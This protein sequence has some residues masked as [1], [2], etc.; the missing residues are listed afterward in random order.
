MKRESRL[1]RRMWTVP[2]STLISRKC[3]WATHFTWVLW[4]AIIEDAIL[5]NNTVFFYL[6][7]CIVVNAWILWKK[8]HSEGSVPPP[9]SEA[10][11]GRTSSRSALS[12]GKIIKN[13]MDLSTRHLKLFQRSIRGLKA[14]PN[15]CADCQVA[16]AGRVTNS[17]SGVW[18][19]EK[20]FYQNHT[21]IEEIHEQ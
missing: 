18:L 21:R 15:H 7:E 12:A 8:A 5:Y 3:S 17:S 14:N 19:H 2:Q 10:P 6:L 20:C 16:E 13:I 9:I 1:T 11:S 4:T